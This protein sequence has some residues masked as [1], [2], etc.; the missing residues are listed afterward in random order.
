MRG[1]G[2]RLKKGEGK[3]SWRREGLSSTIFVFLDFL[4]KYL[5]I[6]YE[7]YYSS[8]HLYCILNSV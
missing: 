5:I 1:A 6:I 4:R 2:W 3:S 8:T 7:F